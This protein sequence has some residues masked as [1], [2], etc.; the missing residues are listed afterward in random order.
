M[1]SQPETKNN[2]QLRNAESW[3]KFFPGM[4]VYFGH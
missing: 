3:G 1:M 2:R 4:N